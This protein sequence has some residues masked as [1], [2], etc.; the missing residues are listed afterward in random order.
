MLR[1]KRKVQ[2]EEEI[3]M[4]PMIDMVFLLLVFF[5]CVSTLAK[6]DK[7]AELTLPESHESQVPDD[8]SDRGVVSVQADGT[9]YLGAE[10]VELEFLKTRIEGVTSRNPDLKI[11]VRA[12]K[13]T[14]FGEIKK[15]LKVCAEV[16]AYEVIYATHQSKG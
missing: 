12:D 16:G 13:N 2:D 7:V 6:A 1:I 3:P 15:V 14:P 10:V 5:M 9:L 8:V 4:A 11:M